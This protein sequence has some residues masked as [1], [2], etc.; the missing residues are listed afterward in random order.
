MMQNNQPAFQSTAANK[1]SIRVRGIESANMTRSY[2]VPVQPIKPVDTQVPISVN[3]HL[4][5][6]CNYKCKFCFATFNDIGK[7]K[8]FLALEDSIKLLNMLKEAGT[9]KVNFV[10]GEPTIHPH[11]KQLLEHSK[12]LG[13][14][15]SIV[16]NG[17]H[18]HKVLDTH[19]QYLDWVGLSV[20]SAVE[21]VQFELQRGYGDHVEKSLVL[22]ERLNNMKIKTKLNTVVTRLNW[23]EDMSWF[24]NVTQPMRWKVFQVLPVD[25]QNDGKVNDLLIT[26]E[27]FNHFLQ[28]HK[29]S[30]PI[31]ED[32]DAMTSS[33]VMIDPLGRFF[34]NTFGF[35]K[36]S[37]PITEIGVEQALK[38]V[39]W[40]TDKFVERDGLYD[41]Q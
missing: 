9:E 18:L 20:D 6:S 19:S 24:L 4:I 36:Y 13:F 37:S 22:F 23:Q 3:L 5:K 16:S 7:V 8:P 39:V 32:N 34:H 17:S 25:G 2:Q 21:S 14:T 35:Y 1:T 15:A 29:S 28:T 11:I 33:Y 10:G 38:Q 26:S 30:N 40:D 27:Q 31:A 12:E 41:W